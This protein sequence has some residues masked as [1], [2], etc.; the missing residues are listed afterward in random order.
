MVDAVPVKGRYLAPSEAGRVLGV[1][2]ARVRQMVAEGKLPAVTT[3]LGRLLPAGAVE[4]EAR[5][6]RQ[7]LP[8]AS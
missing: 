3:S 4:D 8:E 6:R 1:S 7:G 5:R 2:A